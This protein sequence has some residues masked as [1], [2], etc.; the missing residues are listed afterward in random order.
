[1]S[2]ETATRGLRPVTRPNTSDTEY[3]TSPI[4]IAVDKVGSVTSLVLAPFSDEV[5]IDDEE[6]L[7]STTSVAA[8]GSAGCDATLL[9]DPAKGKGQPLASVLL[10]AITGTG[11]EVAL[12]VS[13]LLEKFIGHVAGGVDGARA[14]SNIETCCDDDDDDDDCIFRLFF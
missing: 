1:M 5:V 3:N 13:L 4:D 11:A 8:T 6:R 2:S 7:L 9:A 10:E 14:A 12:L